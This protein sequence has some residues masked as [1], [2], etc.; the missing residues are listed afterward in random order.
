MFAS[1]MQLCLL[2]RRVNKF[3]LRDSE[4]EVYKRCVTFEGS[5]HLSASAPMTGP[6]LTVRPYISKGPHRHELF[7]AARDASC[8]GKVMRL[9]YN[10]LDA[11]HVLWEAHDMPRHRWRQRITLRSPASPSGAEVAF[12]A[13]SRLSACRQRARVCRRIYRRYART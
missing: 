5:D 11:S 7:P 10:G 13:A 4:V 12:T 8:I 6:A 2:D 3:R 9:V 1:W